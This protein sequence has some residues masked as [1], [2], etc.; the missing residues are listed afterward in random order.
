MLIFKL[1]PLEN[2]ERAIREIHENAPGSIVFA[3]GN[4]NQ[5]IANAD[6]VITQQS[7]CTFVA[8]A[9]GKEVYTNLNAAE[10]K[11]LMPIQNGGTSAEHIA[12]ICEHVLH[13]PLEILQER[14]RQV[15][16]RL[17]RER[18]DAY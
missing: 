14:R 7:T 1:H 11:R 16:P 18:A 3:H 15:Q 5:M 12:N 4:I 13:T 17:K 2:V 6:V 9:L 10:L 8:I